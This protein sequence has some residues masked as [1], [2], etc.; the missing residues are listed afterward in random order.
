MRT[1]IED[2]LNVTEKLHAMGIPKFDNTVLS[3][4]FKSWCFSER[5]CSG[6]LLVTFRQ[7]EYF[8][9]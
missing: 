4:Y 3:N 7:R 9:Y 6:A 5:C 1:K 2:T 8:L